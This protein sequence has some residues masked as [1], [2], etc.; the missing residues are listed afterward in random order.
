MISA[1]M[2]GMLA[3]AFVAGAFFASPVPQAIAAVIA[4]DVQ[5]AGCV[6]TAD[7]AGNAV[8]ST[9]IKDGEVKTEDIAAGAI[10]TVRLKDNDVKAQDLA[11]DSVGASELQGVTKLIFAQCTISSSNPLPAGGISAGWVCAALGAL[12]NDSA[13]GTVD[14][15]DSRCFE[16]TRVQPGY[17]GSTDSVIIDIH[18]V[19][20]TPQTPGTLN[21]GVI[22]FHK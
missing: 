11:P 10:G 2:L 20:S 21:I 22:V 4:T 18:N 19:C 1:K 13:V 15:G 12:E 9:K 16:V 7:L 8:T 6:G 17:L 14:G 5:C 3:V